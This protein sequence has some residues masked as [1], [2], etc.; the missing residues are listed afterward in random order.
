MHEC[1]EKL[2]KGLNIITSHKHLVHKIIS[3]SKD[4]VSGLP[5]PHHFALYVKAI[6]IYESIFPIRSILLL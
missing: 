1:V 4:Q 2:I 6:F 5:I 3:S